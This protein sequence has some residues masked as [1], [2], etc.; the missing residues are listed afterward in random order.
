MHSK[1]L[2]LGWI[3]DISDWECI[4]K[5]NIFKKSGLPASFRLGSRSEHFI[6]LM[7]SRH[8]AELRYTVICRLYV[9]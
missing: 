4:E 6:K 2:S 5:T 9:R 7:Y 3:P 8:R 1:G